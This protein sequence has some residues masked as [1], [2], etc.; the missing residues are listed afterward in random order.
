[1]ARPADV[2]R[3]LEE[4][5][6]EE[7]SR[8]WEAKGYKVITHGKIGNFTA[9]LIAKRGAEK[10]VFEVTTAKSLSK[11]REAVERLLRAVAETGNAA[12][13]LVVVN[14]PVEKSIE[15]EGLEAI[16]FQY[17]E[18]NLH[19]TLNE[20]STHTLVEMIN[21]VEVTALEIEPG[22][23]RAT[24]TGIMEVRLQFGSDSDVESDD[25]LLYHDSIP[26]N[27]DVSLD[28]DDLSIVKVH[29]LDIDKSSVYG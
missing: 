26:F 13:R 22:E 14:P 10:I 5:K 16:L 23:I 15:I 18:N 19:D 6:I 17:I 1:M 3:Y 25:G 11:N 28:A 21:D 24:G 7:L 2:S 20:L 4:A 29:R 12:F 8:E 9:D 27:F